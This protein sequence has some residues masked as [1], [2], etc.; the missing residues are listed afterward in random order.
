MHQGSLALV[1]L[2]LS[3]PPAAAPETPIPG[4]E[5]PPSHASALPAPA[6]D[7]FPRACVSCHVVLPDKDTRFSTAMA[8]WQ[9]AVDPALLR[10][11][12][13]AMTEGGA[14]RGKHPAS[15]AD[16]EDIPASC[17]RCH[18]LMTAEAPDFAR[19]I[20]LIHLE[21]GEQNHFLSIFQG[22]CRHCHKLDPSSGRWAVPSGPE[23]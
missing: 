7:P 14:P 23:E 17:Q 2:V 12:Q 13:A 3:V 8:R 10:Y 1:V 20:H 22:D 19:L 4:Q 5:A 18:G 15:G 6:G 21:G 9:E 11:A 16:F